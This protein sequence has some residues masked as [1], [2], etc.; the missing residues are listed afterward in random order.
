MIISKDSKSLT[1]T[2][3]I[4]EEEIWS[5]MHCPV[6]Y[7]LSYVRKVIPKKVDTHVDYIK[8]AAQYFLVNLMDGNL[9]QM[10]DLKKKWDQ[11]CNEH[12]DITMIKSNDGL[13][14]LYK[15][16]EW[17]RKNQ[18]VVLDINVPYA[19]LFPVDKST[20]YD[21]RGFIPMICLTSD[22]IPVLLY[23][24]FSDRA[25]VQ[26]RVD[27]NIKYTMQAYA[28]K[29]Q[30]RKNIGIHVHNIK[31][32]SDFFSMRGQ[33]DFLRLHRTVV[34]IGYSISHNLTYPTDGPL[35]LSCYALQA[36][37]GWGGELSVRN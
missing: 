29:L 27:L 9:I 11:I 6:Q 15:M 13:G 32:D 28:Y 4:D 1:P 35:C 36:C 16:Y 17:S 25:T 10:S 21:V 33:Q 31:F 3:I 34:S 19:V 22:R 18:L 14:K 8:K 30:T 5:F 7:E 12:P 23:F 2:N 20:S 26:E 37:K 24:D